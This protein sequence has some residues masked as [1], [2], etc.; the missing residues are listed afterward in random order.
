[1]FSYFPQF[2]LI[3][4]LNEIKSLKTIGFYPLVGLEI[5]LVGGSR[6]LLKKKKKMD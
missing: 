5:N 4:E 2:A 3:C 1:M 6:Y